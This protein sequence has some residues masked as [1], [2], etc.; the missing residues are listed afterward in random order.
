MYSLSE[1]ITCLEN[2]ELYILN[3]YIFLQVRLAGSVTP[4]YGRLE[5]YD[6]TEG[7]WLAVCDRNFNTNHAR[8]ICRQ[9]GYVDGLVQYGSPLGPTTTK[10]SI[11]EVTCD[12]GLECTFSTGNCGSGRYLA[13]YCTE[14]A[15]TNECNLL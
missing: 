2:L 11:V 1:Y 9:L 10:L 14:T 8:T 15:I 7:E 13:M 4:S 5:M 12:G 6:S 3:I